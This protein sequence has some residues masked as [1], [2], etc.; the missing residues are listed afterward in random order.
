MKYILNKY[1]PKNVTIQFWKKV[2]EGGEKNALLGYDFENYRSK[3]FF[4]EST[5]QGKL[6][7][8]MKNGNIY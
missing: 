4:I 2:I 5:R 8:V 1:V 3:V 7:L 6:F